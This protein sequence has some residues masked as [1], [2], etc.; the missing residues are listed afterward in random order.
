M[1]R[2]L[3]KPSVHEQF[4]ATINLLTLSLED[5]LVLSTA[6]VIMSSIQTFPSFNLVLN[7]DRRVKFSVSFF[8]S[9]VFRCSLT[10]L[11]L[12]N[13]PSGDPSGS[14]NPYRDRASYSHPR[15]GSDIQVRNEDS[16]E[17]C[18]FRAFN[19]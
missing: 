17:Y 16:G 6:T 7:E 13:Y 5:L 10:P 2:C 15:P 9:Y 1:R 18:H 3:V 4:Q 19:F 14:R 12:E 11:A 8:F